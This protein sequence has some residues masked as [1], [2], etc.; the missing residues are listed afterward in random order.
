MPHSYTRSELTRYFFEALD[1]FKE[2]PDSDISKENIL[3]EFFTP[4]NGV[5]VFDGFCGVLFSKL[6]DEAHTEDGY[7]D[8]EVLWSR[9]N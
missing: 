6:L 2:C 1:M 4:S 5:A 3:L 7:F 8:T 9:V